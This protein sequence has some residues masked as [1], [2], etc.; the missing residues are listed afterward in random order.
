MAHQR[1]LL[2]CGIADP[3]A[4]PSTRASDYISHPM[5]RLPISR[6]NF[7]AIREKA[8]RIANEI[9]EKELCPE[10]MPQSLAAG[11]ISLVLRTWLPNASSNE[12]VAKVCSVSE[13]TLLKCLK[14]LEAA[15][16]AGTLILEEKV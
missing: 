16:Q 15:V 12:D 4:M 13:G 10:N 7:Q 5:S 14:K 1:G 6:S 9:E 3:S 8:I 2:A 11:V